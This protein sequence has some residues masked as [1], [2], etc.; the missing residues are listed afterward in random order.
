MNIFF[1]DKSA[2]LAAQ[3]HC[4]KH[5]VKMILETA[6]ILST[7]HRVLDPSGDHAA[8]YKKTHANH[9]SSVWARGSFSQYVWTWKLLSNLC[10]E[11]TE[12]YG[13]VH[14][15]R[16][17]GLLTTLCQVPKILIDSDDSWVD[18]PQCM[19]D[20]FKHECTVKAYRGYYIGSKSRFAKWKKG[21]P[22]W[23]PIQLESN[24][25]Q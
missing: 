1:L 21:S 10:T 23:W 19:P 3:Y 24:N 9:P 25:A 15:V 14:A 12:R 5:C 2:L 20:E 6:Q 13:K 11:Y 16:K 22:Y 18:P 7:A 8:L 4:D 17:S